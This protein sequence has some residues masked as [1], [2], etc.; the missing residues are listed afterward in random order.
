[1]KSV[2]ELLKAVTSGVTKRVDNWRRCCETLSLQLGNCFVRR[3][4]GI[5]KKDKVLRFVFIAFSF[6]FFFF[7]IGRS[8]NMPSA[9]FTFGSSDTFLTAY[10]L[11]V[12]RLCKNGKNYCCAR[13]G[14]SIPATRL[15]TWRLECLLV[16]GATLQIARCFQHW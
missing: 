14:A 9:A 3:E 6:S 15:L 8:I 5:V 10:Y 13:M 12:E 2:N 4:D 1:M 16:R 11:A 7:N